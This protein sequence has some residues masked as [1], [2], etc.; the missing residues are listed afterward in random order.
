AIVVVLAETQFL[1]PLIRV[2]PA[3]AGLDWPWI[4]FLPGGAGDAIQGASVYD[5]VT[6]STLLDPLPWPAGVAVLLA[7]AFVFAVIG[8]FTTWRRDI[9]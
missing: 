4:K 7:W 3:M 5:A 2:V 9:T 8:Y 1:E 6:G